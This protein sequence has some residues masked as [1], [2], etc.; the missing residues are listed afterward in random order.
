MDRARKEVEDIHQSYIYFPLL[1][2]HKIRPQYRKG[3]MNPV[4]EE[5]GYWR[6]KYLDKHPF[7]EL[8]ID[9]SNYMKVW[10]EV[11]NKYSTQL[12][13]KKIGKLVGTIKNHQYFPWLDVEELNKSDVRLEEKKEEK[14]TKI[15]WS[16]KPEKKLF[17]NDLKVNDSYKIVGEPDTL[18][19]K[20]GYGVTGY[21]LVEGTGHLDTYP[22]KKEVVVVNAEITVL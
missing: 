12:I 5:S 2:S 4:H 6:K 13:D 7:I 15:N 19:R 17:F 22:T 21:Q 9:T 3:Q 16:K 11:V 20:I 1:H 8:K 18:Y 10:K 14:M